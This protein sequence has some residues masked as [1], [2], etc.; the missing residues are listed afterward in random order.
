[1]MSALLEGSLLPAECLIS[2][3][4]LLCLAIPPV[5]NIAVTER[6]KKNRLKVFT[7]I[8]DDKMFQTVSSC[9]Q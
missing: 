2:L 4:K 5:L 1:M 3:E 6:I 9:F 7:N 8:S